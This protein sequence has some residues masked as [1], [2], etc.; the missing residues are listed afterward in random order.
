MLLSTS[1]FTD[2]LHHV[3][4]L[5]KRADC[6]G[7]LEALVKGAM[8]LVRQ[9]P[10]DLILVPLD[11]RKNILECVLA[12][13]QSKMAKNLNEKGVSIDLTL[14]FTDAN[15]EAIQDFNR[16]FLLASQTPTQG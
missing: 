3:F 9:N 10:H 11:W 2:Y 4:S 6:E 5:S 8:T 1:T 13:P 14:E 7:L 15:E 16:N 12:L